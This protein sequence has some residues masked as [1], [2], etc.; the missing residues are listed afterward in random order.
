MLI[1]VANTVVQLTLFTACLAISR[2]ALRLDNVG[3]GGADIGKWVLIGALAIGVIVAVV[4]RV[5][6]WR[7]RIVTPIRDGV[8]SVRDVV[9]TPGKLI[10]LLGGTLGSQL[11]YAMCLGASLHA[12]GASL[13]LPT[14][15][16]VNVTATLLGSLSPVPGNLGAAEAALVAGLT[17]A[18]VPTPIA[19]PAALTHRLVTSWATPIAGWFALRSLERHDDI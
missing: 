9:R 10:R 8:R 4:L 19:V 2:A 17:A 13:S 1:G 5:P 12:F 11:L 6:K 3:A 15:V 16:V 18:G 14:L 7:E